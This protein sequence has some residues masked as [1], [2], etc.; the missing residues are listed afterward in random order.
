MNFIVQSAPVCHAH[1]VLVDVDTEYT[2]VI[3]DR[4]GLTGL[5]VVGSNI[6]FT[7][8]QLALN[9]HYNATLTASNI[10]G[11][12]VLHTAL[13]KLHGVQ[14]HMQITSLHTFRYT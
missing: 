4:R 9:R 7:S 10:A 2:V 6:S 14:L 11:S 8:K 13:S 3:E 5:T 12:A 1:L